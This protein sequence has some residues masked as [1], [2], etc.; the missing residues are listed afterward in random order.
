MYLMKGCT[1]IS[2]LRMNDPFIN[3]SSYIIAYLLR[4]FDALFNIV[5]WYC[6][7]ISEWPNER[8]AP[9]HRWYRTVYTSVTPPPP[10]DSI[11]FS[12]R[13]F[14]LL[15]CLWDRSVMFDDSPTPCLGKLLN[16]F[17]E[18]E[19]KQVGSPP[20]P[21]PPPSATFSGHQGRRGIT[22]CI[23]L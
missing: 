17:L 16:L 5:A 10:P 1:C 20:P 3:I 8:N 13:F 11:L 21:P 4:H 14:F 18:E 23:Q 19:K 7:I 15:A 22:A 2:F 6:N 9:F 12:V